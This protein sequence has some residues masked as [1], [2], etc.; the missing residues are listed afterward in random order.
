MAC[1]LRELLLIY[2]SERGEKG[3]AFS[4]WRHSVCWVEER[5][6]EGGG[7][8]G[9]D[10]GGLL[11]PSL[12]VQFFWPLRSVSLPT[13]QKRA[14]IT[15]A[16]GLAFPV[17]LVYTWNAC[18]RDS[19]FT[20]RFTTH[21]LLCGI[22]IRN[23]TRAASCKHLHPCPHCHFSRFKEGEVGGGGGLSIHRRFG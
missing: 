21:T 5:G 19:T 16:S 15:T 4:A 14:F 6:R 13:S 9:G 7:G 22:W 18:E 17:M 2:Q 3:D 8:G 12:I 23:K 10:L 1:T 11:L 20:R